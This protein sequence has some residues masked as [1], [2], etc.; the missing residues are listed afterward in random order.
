[1]ERPIFTKFLEL[2]DEYRG[3]VLRKIGK[4]MSRHIQD[5]LLCRDLGRRHRFEELDEESIKRLDY[6]SE[7][8]IKISQAERVQPD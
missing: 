7:G 6:D 8:L 4:G 2:L 3:P 5:V 1:M